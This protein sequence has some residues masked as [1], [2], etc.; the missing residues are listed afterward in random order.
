M[1]AVKLIRVWTTFDS[2]WYRLSSA[3]G[4]GC[5]PP[6]SS[7]DW[8]DAGDP[9]AQLTAYTASQRFSTRQRHL[10][11]GLAHSADDE[12]VAQRTATCPPG[13]G[14]LRHVPSVSRCVRAVL[15]VL[16]RI[17]GA[18]HAGARHAGAL[19]AVTVVVELASLAGCWRPSGSAQSIYGEPAA[20]CT[21]TTPSQ[22]LSAQRR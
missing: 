20:Q 14:P 1:I 12:P 18:L 19:P 17:P 7:G 3:A 8:P 13:H 4:L 9:A 2:S 15:W 16:P 10:A 22:Q 11:S 5:T 6:S 21:A